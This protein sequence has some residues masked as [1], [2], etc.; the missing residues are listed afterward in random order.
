MTRIKLTDENIIDYRVTSDSPFMG[1]LIPAKWDKKDE[2]RGQILEDQENSE[3]Y[4][5]ETCG[6]C[7]EK[8]ITIG[9]RHVHACKHDLIN[10]EKEESMEAI[11]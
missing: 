6:Y 2:I 8:M 3:L 10:T 7:N 9:S 4:L 1:L 11:P 5:K